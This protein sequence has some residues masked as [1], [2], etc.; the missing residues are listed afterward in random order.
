MSLPFGWFIAMLSKAVTKSETLSPTLAHD[1]DPGQ[2][3]CPLVG[4]HKP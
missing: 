1:L 3:R 4:G 2:T